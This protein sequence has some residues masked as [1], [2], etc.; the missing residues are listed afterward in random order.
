LLPAVLV[1]RLARRLRPWTGNRPLAALGLAGGAGYLRALAEAG[2]INF[3]P[4]PGNLMA[5]IGLF[6]LTVI[7]HELGHAAAL[8]RSGYPPGGIG[9]GLLFVVPVMY[10]DVTAVG[11][12]PKPGRLRVDA[13]GVIFQIAPGG[14]MMALAG[15]P[16]CPIFLVK[17]LTLAGSSVLLAVVWSLFPFVRSDGYW[18]LC[19]LL[20][21]DDLERPP[22]EQVPVVLRVFL[23]VYQL[24]NAGFLLMLGFY[25]PLRLVRLVMGFAQRAGLTLEPVAANWLTTA[26]VLIF[27]GALGMG[28]ARR[29]GTLVGAAL[30]GFRGLISPRNAFFQ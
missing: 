12:L 21:L 29:I 25:V 5:G 11:V 4:D 17:T 27:M 24:A 20:G 9:F 8:A 19:D 6:L 26:L 23:V 2:P 7:W 3:S 18:L 13:A 10:A 15:V 28:L 14:L 22:R 16:G 30:Q 1:C